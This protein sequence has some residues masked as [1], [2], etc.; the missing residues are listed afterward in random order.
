MEKAKLVAIKNGGC[1]IRGTTWRC[2]Y[3][4]VFSMTAGK[5][6]KGKWC[7]ACGAS[8]GERELKDIL[9]QRGVHFIPQAVISQLPHRMYDF[10]F[11][12]G[13]IGYMVEFDGEQHF[14]YVR[15]YHKSKA[16]FKEAQRIDWLKTNTALQAGY[17]VIRIDYTQK[18]NIAWHLDYAVAG[19]YPLY[20]SNREMYRYLVTPSM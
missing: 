4:H 7:T 10:Y 5:V 14:K 13:N 1:N 15:K 18:G 3:G 16:G 17:R 9:T 19:G 8:Q 2:K 20:L 11:Q 12:Y 6:C